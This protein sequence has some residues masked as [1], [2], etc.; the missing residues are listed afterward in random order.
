M[1]WREEEENEKEELDEE[2]S[3][4]RFK[5]QKMENSTIEELE[6][7]PQSRMEE[8]DHEKDDE[9]KMWPAMAM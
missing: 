9:S 4:P 2:F 3:P 1:C 8:S 5:K 7:V 6:E